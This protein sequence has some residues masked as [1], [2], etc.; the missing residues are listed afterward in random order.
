MPSELRLEVIWN[1]M[2]L[3][4]LLLLLVSPITPTSYA[5]DHLDA[6]LKTVGDNWKQIQTAWDKA[7]ADQKDGLDISVD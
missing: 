5:E 6:A 3:Y 4:S 2:L 1:A 7:A